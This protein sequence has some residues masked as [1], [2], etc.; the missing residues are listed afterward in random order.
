[1]ENF[2]KSLSL[3]RQQQQFAEKISTQLE[4]NHNKNIDTL[5]DKGNEKHGELMDTIKNINNQEVFKDT[6]NG[7]IEKVDEAFKKQEA[8]LNEGEKIQNEIK[9]EF[10][11]KEKSDE[12]FKIINNNSSS[13]N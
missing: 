7:D 8:I 2:E 11:K 4:E 13:L 10:Y 1:M 5:F 3:K 6:F 12:N 9:E